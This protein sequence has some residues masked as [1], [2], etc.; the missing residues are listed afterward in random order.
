MERLQKVLAHAGVASRRKCEELILAG[1]VSVDGEIVTQLGAKVDPSRQRIAVDGV[2]IELEQP[3]VLVLNKPVAY[4]STV[5]DPLGRRTV[6]QLLPPIRERVYPVGRLDYDTSGLL[7]FTNDGELTQRLLHPSREIEKVYRVSVRGIVDRET[8][9]ALMEGVEL[10]DGVTAPAKVEV[11]RQADREDGVAVV[12]LAIHEGRNRQVRRMFERLGLPVLRLKR[13]AFGPVSLGHLKTGEWRALT[14]EEWVALYQAAGM[15]PPPYRRPTISREP[16]R[17]G[18][19]RA[20]AR[21]HGS[22]RG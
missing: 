14:Q 13:I 10:E 6:M 4:L 18:A 17:K 16:A 8:R 2:P 9:R 5:S 12:H 15:T 19:A 11:L 7:L 20:S 3:V 1:R 22:R 21:D